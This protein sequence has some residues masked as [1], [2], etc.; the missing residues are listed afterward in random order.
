MTL[1]VGAYK[2]ARKVHREVIKDQNAFI[3][4]P[5]GTTWPKIAKT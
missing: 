5:L 1:R 3:K 4:A 2:L